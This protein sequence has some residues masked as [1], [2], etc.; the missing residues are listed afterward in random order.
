MS[1]AHAGCSGV[2]T[3]RWSVIPKSGYRFS[4]KITRNVRKS[5]H[6][7]A[8]DRELRVARGTLAREIAGHRLCRIHADDRAILHRRDQV[9]GDHGR[10]RARRHRDL[11]ADTGAAHHIAGHAD[12][13]QILPPAKRNAGDR[14]VLDDVAG[15]GGVGFDADADAIA[16]AWVGANR[17]PGHQ[18]ADEIALD[19][20]HAAALFEI[21]HRDADGGAIDRVVGDH[22][23]LE[24]ELRVDRDFAER[25]AGVVGDLDVGRRI[26]AHRRERRIADTV[27]AHADIMRA[28]HV[29][30]VAVLSR[31]AGLRRDVLDAVVD[32]LR[33]VVAFLRAPYLNAVV[34]D[35]AD[36]V[37]RDDK[38]ARVERMDRSAKRTRDGRAGDLALD[39]FEHDTVAARADDLAIADRDPAPGRELNQ[40]GILR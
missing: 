33:A 3:S 28:I 1:C 11:D 35:I 24:T 31:A 23:A 22:R 40:A 8:V 2:F 9:V 34:G 39:A 17:T 29:D 38:A 32:H 18:I 25:R 4:D 14:R 19:D 16:I 21:C 15:D 12:V 30:R 20:G 13:A 37:A 36:G 10:A 26:A 5:A 27:A 7:V 6:P